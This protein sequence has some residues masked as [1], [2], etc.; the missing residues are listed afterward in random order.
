[1]KTAKIIFWTALIG[2]A[3]ISALYILLLLGGYVV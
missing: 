2:A 3:S 1:M